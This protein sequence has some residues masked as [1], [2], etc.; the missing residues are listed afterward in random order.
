MQK[1]FCA[2]KEPLHHIGGLRFFYYLIVW[3]RF[4]RNGTTLFWMYPHHFPAGISESYGF[5]AMII[6]CVDTQ[7]F[8]VLIRQ[9]DVHECSPPSHNFLQHR[10]PPAQNASCARTREAKSIQCRGTPRVNPNQEKAVFS[11][12]GV[13]RLYVEVQL[14]NHKWKFQFRNPSFR[15]ILREN[16]FHSSA[17]ACY[18]WALASHCAIRGHAHPAVGDVIGSSVFGQVLVGI[19]LGQRPVGVLHLAQYSV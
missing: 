3:D 9:A 12:G 14:A 17:C 7:F 2:V 4:S 13:R 8:K 10:S 18:T 1:T 15:D 5:L 16:P 19:A 11:E 6:L